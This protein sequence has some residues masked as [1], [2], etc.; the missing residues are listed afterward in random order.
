[1]Q[2]ER[3]YITGPVAYQ[4]C[5]AILWWTTLLQSCICNYW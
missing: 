3:E 1:V 5:L 2:K 4:H